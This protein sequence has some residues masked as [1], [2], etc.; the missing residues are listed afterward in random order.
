V[1]LGL[2]VEG[3]APG[4]PA[5]WSRKEESVVERAGWS[6][7]VE[8]GSR[9]EPRIEEIMEALKVVTDPEIGVNVV[10]LG[11]VYGVEVKDGDVHVLMTLTTVG[12]PLT[13][14]LEQMVQLALGGVEGVKSVTVEW[15]FD[16]PWTPERL[17]EEGR[18]QL[19]MLGFAL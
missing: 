16:P 6:P 18:E 17:T 14:W 9:G 8:G 4:D 2:K 13:D 10:D 7:A 15:T 5:W 12:C 19:R 1:G 3:G 11:L